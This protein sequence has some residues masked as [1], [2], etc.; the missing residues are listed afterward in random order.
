MKSPRT[1]YLLA[2]GLFVLAASVTFFP[3]WTTHAP[4][5]RRARLFQQEVPATEH[6]RIVEDL[7]AL[8]QRVNAKIKRGE[9]TPAALTDELAAFDALVE[10]HRTS[11]QTSKETAE[12][13]AAVMA[14]KADLYFQVLEDFEKGADQLRRLKADFPDTEYGRD[15]DAQ[16]AR[17][18][19]DE[20]AAKIRAT[21][22]VGAVFPDFEA[23]QDLGGQP[24]SLA[25]L[26]GKVVLVDFWATW[27]GPCVAELPN[28]I[29]AYEKFHPR[30]LE[31]VGISLD[32]SEDDLRSFIAAQK[33][34]WR[35][36]FDG[37]GWENRVA[38]KYGVQSIPTTYLLDRDGRIA[39]SGLRGAELDAALEKLLGKP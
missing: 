27:C 21:L 33:M 30:G 26:K 34:T 19:A 20:A 18:A 28:V 11:A 31:I 9:T 10:R 4:Q 8:V 35:Q 24:L 2:A 13:L 36:Y 39:G 6:N 3:I 17:V 38:A 14:S 32:K 22:Q 23:A 5:F 16:L 29:A 37:L 7:Q 25:A 12:V 15:V 1:K